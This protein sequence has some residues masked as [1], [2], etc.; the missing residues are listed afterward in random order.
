L[1]DPPWRQRSPGEA[2][3]TLAAE[4]IAAG[5]TADANSRTEILQAIL[6]L[7]G[8]PQVARLQRVLLSA[9]ASKVPA[10]KSSL[11]AEIGKLTDEADQQQVRDILKRAAEFAADTQQQPAQRRE[12]IELLAHDPEAASTLATLSLEEPSSDVRSQALAALS[13]RSELEP[14]K[15]L[16]DR[17]A[18]ESPT[19]RRVI[20]TGL[21]ARKER[22]AL[23]LD[24][25]EAGKIKPAELERAQAG[26]LLKH[27]DATLRKRA[28]VLLA[29]AVPADRKQVLADYQ[30]VLKMKSDPTRGRAVFKKNCVTCHRVGDLGVEVAPDISDSRT[31]QETQ[32]L[33]DIL[34]P[35]RAIDNNYIS[36][37]VVTTS[38]IL[39]NGIVTSETATSFTLRQPEGKDV[40]LLRSE[41]EEIRSSGV[42][43]MP[44]GLEKSIP[45][46]EMAD[47]I[48]FIKNWRYLDG[49]TPLG[50]R[51][52]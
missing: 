1:A 39:L 25:I 32:I 5:V 28:G 20:V 35:N 22:T 8:G 12:V 18:A 50:T 14:W 9:F 21:L 24:G 51:D 6:D 30:V 7:A 27:G 49:K 11:A 34:Q 31:K 19:I 46:Q 45:H 43:L 17:F 41:I 36:Y 4:L 33:A 3:L 26:R 47:L 13:R 37:A 38:G 2:D 29:A 23:L 15:L 44:D 42:S 10:R 48:S 52:E 16:I 40:T